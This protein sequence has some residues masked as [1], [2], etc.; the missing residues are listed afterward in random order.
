MKLEEWQLSCQINLWGDR[1]EDGMA[2][3]SNTAIT[4]VELGSNILMR[5]EHEAGKWMELVERHRLAISAVYEFGHFDNWNRRREIYLHHDRLA[6]LLERSAINTVVLGPGLIM[7]RHRTTQDE[8]RLLRSILEV[9]K[10]Y[11]AHGVNV[12]IHPHWAHCIFMEDEIDRLME[13]TPNRIGLVP[14]LG[15]IAEAGMDILSLLQKYISRIPCIHIKDYKPLVTPPTRIYERRM[16]FCEVGQGVANFPRLF[17]MLQKEG[18]KGWLTLEMENAKAGSPE[19][20]IHS[21]I[22]Y[23]GGLEV[24]NQR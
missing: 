17:R 22:D 21:M 20:V 5:Y 23:L 9:S 13:N 16:S 2:Y 1:Y 18:Y 11:E 7:Q 24:G 19:N 14:D 3:L 15:H 6:S 8:G 12:A 10:R 4:A